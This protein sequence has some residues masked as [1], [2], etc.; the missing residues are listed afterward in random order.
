MGAVAH[1]F[2]QNAQEDSISTSSGQSGYTARPCLKTV[3]HTNTS[4]SNLEF[5][6]DQEGRGERRVHTILLDA[7]MHENGTLQLINLYFCFQMVSC[8][9]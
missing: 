6:G 5:P 4:Q 2:N 3:I 1:A 8:L 9:N 7:C